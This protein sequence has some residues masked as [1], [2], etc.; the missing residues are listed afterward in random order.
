MKLAIFAYSRQGC[1]TAQKIAAALASDADRCQCYAPAKYADGEFSPITPPCSSFT[2]P[3][4]SWADTL[5][6][7][8]AA[9]IAVRSIAPYVKDKR[10]DPAVLCVDELGKFVIP[11]LSGHIGGANALAERLAAQLHATSVITT[12]TDLHQKFS[13]DAWASAQ[14][15]AITSMHAAKLVSAAILEGPVPL[16]CDFPIPGGLPG[17]TVP[18]NTGSIGI[19]ISWRTKHPFAETLLLVPP[20]L[21]LGLGCRRG[22]PAEQ[23]AK[24]VESVLT[25]HQIHPMA[26][27]CAASIDLKRDEAGL[28]EYCAAQGWPISFYSAAELRRL[29]GDFTPSERVLRMTGVDNVCERSAMTGADRL[30]V[31]KTIRNGVTIAVA[32][33]RWEVSFGLCPNPPGALPLDPAAL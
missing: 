17:G 16:D 27:K 20:V 25:E 26:V 32:L 28:L 19:C 4:F 14:G 7:V 18:G 31:P 9:G 11:L 8:G 15:L 2:G 33:E 21:H 6:F 22:T 29:E 13:V 1:Q 30:L 10:T 24:A 5:I 23:I 12:A 3:I